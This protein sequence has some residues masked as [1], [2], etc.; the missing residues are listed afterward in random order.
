[1]VDRIFLD[2][3]TAYVMQKRTGDSYIKHDRAVQT[4]LGAADIIT[5]TPE[6][7]MPVAGR[8]VDMIKAYLPPLLFD[9]GGR[10]VMP[11]RM[12]YSVHSAEAGG[13]EKVSMHTLMVIKDK[14][15]AET[16]QVMWEPYKGESDGLEFVRGE[17]IVR[18]IEGHEERL[19]GMVLDLSALEAEPRK[20][21]ALQGL[22]KKLT[23]TGRRALSR[24][25]QTLRDHEIKL[26]GDRRYRLTPAY[27]PESGHREPY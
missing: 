2:Q 1:M 14:E 26:V 15:S 18:E 3:Q 8:P 9:E 20:I 22:W 13:E 12:W 7:V 16:I 17:E 10:P 19:D 25:I 6:G 27:D 11:E 4:P 21:S 23:R 24:Q 5:Y